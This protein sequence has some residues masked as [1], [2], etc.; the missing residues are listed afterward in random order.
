MMASAAGLGGVTSGEF[1]PR[2]PARPANGLGERV[3]SVGIS[4]ALFCFWELR[5]AGRG[6]NLRRPGIQMAAAA[7]HTD[8][9]AAAGAVQRFEDAHE[10]VHALGTLVQPGFDEVHR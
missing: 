5:N 8:R 3:I 7:K 4:A 10:N 1:I 2:I 6:A 9:I